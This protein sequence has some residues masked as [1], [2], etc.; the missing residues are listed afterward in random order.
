MAFDPDAIYYGIDGERHGPVD[1]AEL[2]A[3]LSAGDISPDD[4]LWDEDRQD[5]FALRRFPIVFESPAPETDPAPDSVRTEYE[6]LVEDHPTA[7]RIRP[8]L[9][10]AGFGIR[11][12]A[13]IIDDLVLLGP[14]FLMLITM[15]NLSG[16][17]FVEIW[18]ASLAG[19]DLDADQ[20]GFLQQFQAGVFVI[21][22]LY[23][24][25]MES[26][27]WQGTVGKRFL[28]LVVTDDRGYRL[29]FV[30]V[31]GRYFGRILCEMTFFL[32][33]LLVFLSVK[34]QGLHDR[35]ASTVVVRGR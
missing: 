17:D 30:R 22:G 15:E 1:L 20:R 23:W 31:V 26:S 25:T 16:L 14:V 2:R 33:Y 7:W 9:P 34:H 29:S 6:P 18:Q 35:L 28:G 32:G 4:Y 24:S 8:D 5:W 11:F 19:E 3:L 21:R 13:W 10:Y 27:R 12:A